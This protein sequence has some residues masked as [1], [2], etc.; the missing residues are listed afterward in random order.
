MKFVR[1]EKVKFAF[2]TMM[3]K[4][5]FAKETILMPYLKALKGNSENKD[6]QRISTLEQQISDIAE[7]QNTIT[8]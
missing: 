8:C 4:L 6:M 2:L 5:I 1:D 3:N 7:Q